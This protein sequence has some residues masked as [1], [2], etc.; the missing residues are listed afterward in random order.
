MAYD[1]V[2]QEV[3][4]EVFLNE[5]YSRLMVPADTFE[6]MGYTIVQG[7]DY[8]AIYAVSNNTNVT[9][10]SFDNENTAMLG[11]T[12]E[13]SLLNDEGDAMV[14]DITDTNCTI[15]TAAGGMGAVISISAIESSVN[16]ATVSFTYNEEKLGNTDEEDLKL[17]WLNEITGRVELL[18]NSSVDIENNVVS[19]DVSHFSQ[20]SVVD[21]KEWYAA[22]E[23]TQLIKRDTS[24]GNGLYYV[25]LVLDVSGSMDG[26]MQLLK[27]S[28]INFIDNLQ[29][30]DFIN[31]TTF[32]DGADTI[33][34]DVQKKDVDYI[35]IINRLS[36]GGGTDMLAGLK[37]VSFIEVL[38]VDA[39]EEEKNISRLKSESTRITILLSD[40]NPDSD[41]SRED[42]L[43]E[44]R[45]FDSRFISVALGSGADTE[46]MQEIAA[47]ANGSYRYIDSA[48]N[49]LESFGMLSGE[50]IG[51]EED[52]DGDGIPDLIETTGMRDEAGRIFKT[53]PNNYDTDGDLLSDGD[54]MGV[55]VDEDGGYFIR[56]SDPT[57]VTR[58]ESL[59]DSI[60]YNV[61]NQ[62]GFY[63]VYGLFGSQVKEYVDIN[64]H[65][66][67]VTR[68][69]TTE[70]DGRNVEKLY[71]PIQNLKFD[72]TKKP[73]CMEVLVPPEGKDVLD[74]E[75]TAFTSIRVACDD[76]LECENNHDIEI[77]V[78]GDNLDPIIIPVS[79]D[80]KQLIVE[81]ANMRLNSNVKTPISSAV[82]TQL[83][84]SITDMENRVNAESQDNILNKMTINFDNYDVPE[85][86][87]TAVR[88]GI[89]NLIADRQSLEKISL[90]GVQMIKDS[91]NLIGIIDSKTIKVPLDN[92]TYVVEFNGSFNPQ[93]SIGDYFF[94]ISF[95]N[96]NCY[97]EGNPSES[98]SFSY[99]KMDKDE[100]T[101]F[102]DAYNLLLNDLSNEAANEA[103]KALIKGVL[104]EWD[105]TNLITQCTDEILQQFG[106][107]DEVNVY[108]QATDISDMLSSGAD[109]NDIANYMDEFKKS[110]E[111]LNLGD[112][113]VDETVD[114]LAEVF[115]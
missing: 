99:T 93:I 17:V 60:K 21:S 46:L 24:T 112:A 35:N 38:P 77:T 102:V 51:L 27:D 90:D 43:N 3:S 45:L 41:N 69:V 30:D 109:F 71:A 58:Y 68:R 79:L 7:D 84:C 8:L 47:A 50:V 16:T 75:G 66:A 49:L 108:K 111:S 28:V 13:Y 57:M 98:Y 73:D 97:V 18:E 89:V 67:P 42:I 44:S 91:A 110:Y 115:K 39:T 95:I 104:Q 9:G 78:S 114:I 31:I 94:N 6:K 32:S 80:L 29:D 36:A 22:W 25:D 48:D 20:Y 83:T 53:D 23:K 59:S 26:S 100:I 113:L 14:S 61:K 92:K 96:G 54:E 56:S 65:I 55:F 103:G 107:F 101:A 85:E 5:Y 86:F 70:S 62:A 87:N 40:G 12:V 106:V 64:L 76:S 52:T 82:K 19:A 15:S 33:I 37:E 2:S 34:S 1:G 4:A 72:I 74:I 10:V 88:I 105:M 81:A 63:E 11:A